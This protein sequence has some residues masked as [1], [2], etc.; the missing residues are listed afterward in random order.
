MKLIYKLIRLFSRKT[1]QSDIG[2]LYTYDEFEQYMD[3]EV[4]IKGEGLAYYAD[5][6][7][8]YGLVDDIYNLKKRYTHIMWYDK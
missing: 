2:T 6:T 3:W 8:E 7:H 4:I 5:A 1:G